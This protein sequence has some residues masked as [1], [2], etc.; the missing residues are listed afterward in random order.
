MKTKTLLWLSAALAAA[1]SHQSETR[2]P[3]SSADR[4]TLTATSGNE[5]AVYRSEQKTEYRTRPSKQTVPKRD[6]NDDSSQAR[7]KS[8]L[9]APGTHLDDSGN[10]VSNPPPTSTDASDGNDQRSNSTGGDVDTSG[11]NQ[12]NAERDQTLTTQI[13]RALT[14]DDSLSPTAKNIDIV[15]TEGRVTLRGTVKSAN[16]R[17]TIDNFARRIAGERAVDNQIEVKP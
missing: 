8:Y 3:T 11:M 2:E 16:E 9:M 4:T 10:T 5:S 17:S 15:A 12:G 7:A 13:R 6:A 14:G 1:C